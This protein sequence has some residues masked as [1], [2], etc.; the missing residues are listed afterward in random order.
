MKVVRISKNGVC[1]A[2]PS[3]NQ[4]RDG[5]KRFFTFNHGSVG[6]GRWEVRFPLG[7]RDFPVEHDDPKSP[8]PETEYKLI[9]LKR[10]DPE[11][12]GQY[13]LGKGIK[14]GSYLVLWS[15]SPGF[16]GGATFAVTGKAKVIATGEEAQGD[17]GRMG[18][19]ACPVVY[20]TGPCILT[21]E[22]SG[23]IYGEK[24]SWVAEFDGSQWYV[25]PEDECAIESAIF[26]Y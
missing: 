18:G 2:S 13:L 14:D 12:N 21:W 8:D 10:K 24:G 26:E 25:A 11:G 1:G 15:L 16:R 19:A 3:V 17:A 20:V 5:G 9:D 23:R 4:T 22:R 6:R 7:F